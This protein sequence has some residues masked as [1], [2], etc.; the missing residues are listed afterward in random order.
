MELSNPTARP[1]AA[2]AKDLMGSRTRVTARALLVGDR[3]DTVGLERSDVLSASPL[4]FR[5]GEGGVATLF[6]YGV[7]VLTGLTP[8]EEDEV[9]RSIRPRISGEFK[10][11]EEES[12][13]VEVSEER[14]DQI[15]AG[16]PIQV[17]EISP[18]RLIVISEALAKSVV[19]ANDEREVAAVFEKTEPLARRLAETG[20]T[21]GG[22]R[23]ILAHIGNALLVQHRVSGRV[24]VAEKPDVLWDR[25]DLER[26]YARLENEYEL[27][28]RLDG[29]NRKLAVIAES[30]KALTDI[31]DT[32]RSLR[33]EFI[34]VVL[35]VL[36]I[37]IASYQIFLGYAAH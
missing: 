10:I 15:P 3:L 31:I 35:I 8:L 24:A 23:T 5:V 4:S 21:P 13:V 36:E 33:L 28:E 20:R 7:V 30:A 2:T 14:E 22:R 18:D 1:R 17:K 16:G 25:P 26:L 27:K 11:R 12:A 32:E 37:V 19:L 29:L 6:R 34:I 9:L